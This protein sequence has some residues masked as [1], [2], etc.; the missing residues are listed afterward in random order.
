MSTDLAG[1]TVTETFSTTGGDL[2]APYT[3]SSSDDATVHLVVDAGVRVEEFQ[4]I[5][6]TAGAISLDLSGPGTVLLEGNDVYSGGLFCPA[7]CCN[8]LE[9]PRSE[10]EAWSS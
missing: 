8:S 3:N 9:R 6:Q 4:A 2:N 10:R 1:G 5:D 7:A